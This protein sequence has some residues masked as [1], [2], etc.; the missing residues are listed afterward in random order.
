MPLQHSPLQHGRCT[1][2]EMDSGP[3]ERRDDGQAA[4]RARARGRTDKRTDGRTEETQFEC[5]QIMTKA[6]TGVYERPEEDSTDPHATL[7]E[8]FEGQ[9]NS[10]KLKADMDVHAPICAPRA[11]RPAPNLCSDHPPPPQP[12]PHAAKAFAEC[13][14]A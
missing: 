7:T 4:R 5:G 11:P 3:A 13:P 14:A 2:D 6:H 12:A 10:H 1:N 8:F 9:R